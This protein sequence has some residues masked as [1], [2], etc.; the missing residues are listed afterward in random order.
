[1]TVPISTVNVQMEHAEMTDTNPFDL[2]GVPPLTE[3]PPAK[4]PPRKPRPSEMAKKAAKSAAKTVRVPPPKKVPAKKF[5]PKAVKKVAKAK[6]AKKAAKAAPKRKP[7][8]GVVRM[9]RLDFRLSKTE[10]A[11]LVAKARKMQRTITSIV[12]EAIGKLAK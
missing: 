4:K 12:A 8:S 6:P 3:A 11:R 5:K 10:K 7:V 2:T 1:M 9:E